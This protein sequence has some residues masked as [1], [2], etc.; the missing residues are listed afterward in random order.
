MILLLLL[1][2]LLIF[3]ATIAS[4]ANSP[5]Q[6][7]LGFL[8]HP[9]TALLVTTLVAMLFFGFA[10]GLDRDRSRKMAT[11]SLAPIGTLLVIMGGGGAFK[12]VIVDSGVGPYAGQAAGH[13]EH[14]AADGGLHGGGRHARGAGFGDGRHHHGGRH[15]RAAGEVDSRIHA[16]R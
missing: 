12:Q 5:G 14:F 1:P 8:G 15:R 16:R 6:N 4:L 2:V 7:V 13:F 11:E 9:F 10:R 3:A